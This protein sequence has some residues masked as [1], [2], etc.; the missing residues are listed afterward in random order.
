MPARVERRATSARFVPSATDWRAAFRR[1]K[2]AVLLAS[3]QDTTCPKFPRGG[4]AMIA[5]TQ[6]PQRG[7]D[8]VETGRAAASPQSQVSS[9][10]PLSVL[11]IDD[12]LD[13]EDAFLPLLA[14]KGVRIDVASSGHAGLAMAR[15][16]SYDEIMLDLRLPD[17]FGM[18]VLDRLI[19]RDRRAPIVVVSGYYLE[20]EIHAEAARRGAATF[21]H[22]PFLDPDALAATLRGLVRHA[23]SGTPLD[24]LPTFGIVAV[25]ETMRIVADRIRRIGPTHATVLITGETGTGKDLVAHALHQASTRRSRPFVPVNCAAI[26]EA[27]VES[28][29]FGHRKGAFTGALND[30]KGL[31]EAADGGTLFL[32]E[33]GDLPLVMQARLLRCLDNGEVRRVGETR[34]TRGDVGL[35]GATHRSLP[36]GIVNGRFRSALHYRISVTRFHVPPL[37]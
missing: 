29:F 33:I 13:A 15:P 35:I 10:D 19:A 26:P 24:R 32:D 21:L 7:A 8:P 31:F 22:K 18:T 2:R 37:R 4:H 16:G 20:P 36:D 23:A 11:W 12:E 14:F 17:L 1:L 27:L 34:A 3:H 25:S 5:A 30:H 28:E 9:L 6:I